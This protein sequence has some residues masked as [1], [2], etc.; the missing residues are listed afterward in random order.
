MDQTQNDY[1]TQDYFLTG[2]GYTFSLNH[3]KP[4]L[5]FKYTSLSY[6]INICYVGPTL[7]RTVSSLKIRIHEKQFFSPVYCYCQIIFD[8]SILESNKSFGVAIVD[9]DFGLIILETKNGYHRKRYSHWGSVFGTGTPFIRLGV[10]GHLI[11]KSRIIQWNC[12]L[13]GNIR[14]AMCEFYPIFFILGTWVFVCRSMFERL[15]QNSHLQLIQEKLFRALVEKVCT[16]LGW[17]SING[18]RYSIHK[19]ASFF[20]NANVNRTL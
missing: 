14:L 15:Q 11:Y 10:W 3:R 5:P 13:H 4:S 12:R 6:T 2:F 19:V 17:L 9:V 18:Y 16:L 1:Y 20:G 8:T 7:S